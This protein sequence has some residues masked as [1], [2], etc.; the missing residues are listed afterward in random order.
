MSVE[1]PTLPVRL[2][3]HIHTE[4]VFWAWLYRPIE[5]W[6]MNGARTVARIQTG[7]LRHYLAYSFFTLVVLLWLVV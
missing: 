5:H 7:Q 3:Y 1:L 4:D 6:V 2:S